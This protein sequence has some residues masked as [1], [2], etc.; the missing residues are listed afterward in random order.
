MIRERRS[1]GKNVCLVDL[2]V[3]CF[4]LVCFCLFVCLF[5][6]F[7]CFLVCLL[8][9][10]KLPAVVPQCSAS[11]DVWGGTG[12]SR[13]LCGIVNTIYLKTDYDVVRGFLS[14][15]FF[16]TMLSK[17]VAPWRPFF[18]FAA[19]FRLSRAAKRPLPH[20][21]RP[22]KTLGHGGAISMESVW[23]LKRCQQCKQRVKHL[24]GKTIRNVQERSKP[25]NFDKHR[26]ET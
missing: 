15:T 4:D 25:A 17:D 11:F 12:A 8:P 26:H 2:I 19:S 23:S 7:A 16:G 10:L 20:I 5:V 24:F 14:D 18:F 3:V 13:I 6:C 9:L 21:G 1:F 22:A